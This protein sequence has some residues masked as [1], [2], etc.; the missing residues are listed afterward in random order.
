MIAVLIFLLGVMNLSV[1]AQTPPAV[2]VKTAVTQ[3]ADFGP[4]EVGTTV[5]LANVKWA[6]VREF[7]ADY[8]LWL[9]NYERIKVGQDVRVE[10]DV[11]LRTAATLRSGSRTAERHVSAILRDP[12]A[13]PPPSYRRRLDDFEAFRKALSETFSE[14]TGTMKAEATALGPCICQAAR[15]M[16]DDAQ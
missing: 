11:Q 16:L 4:A 3:K 14:A 2:D 8:A 13:D 15:S 6:R 1:F 10:M 7:G 9:K 12:G 5:C